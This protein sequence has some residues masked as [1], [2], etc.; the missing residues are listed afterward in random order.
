MKKK[1][2]YAIEVASSYLDPTLMNHVLWEARDTRL[3]LHIRFSPSARHEIQYIIRREDGQ[4]SQASHPR[5]QGSRSRFRLVE[6]PPPGPDALYQVHAGSLD[7]SG[8][9]TRL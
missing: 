8:L 7:M 5:Q 6:E 2:N 1:D 3:S 9:C 4:S